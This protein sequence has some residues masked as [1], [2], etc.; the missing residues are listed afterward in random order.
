MLIQGIYE[1]RC[2]EARQV[3]KV[4]WPSDV[5]L[6]DPIGFQY[7]VLGYAPTAV[8]CEAFIALRDNNRLVWKSGR[9][10]GKSR[11]LAGSALWWHCCNP[12]STIV[13]GAG[14]ERQISEVVYSD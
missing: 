10:C 1:Q 4:R 14:C 2:N 8:Q 6:N 11:F 3:S 7:D 12:T 13:L 5:Y 9:R